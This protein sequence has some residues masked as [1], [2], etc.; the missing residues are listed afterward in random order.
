MGIIQELIGQTIA[1]II[2]AEKGQKEILFT[3]TDG[4]I[5]RMFHSQYC[6]ENV[7]VE[8]VCGDI[9]DLIGCP[10]VRAEAPSTENEPKPSEEYV[11]SWTWTFYILGTQKGTVTF[12]W[13]GESNG[14]YSEDVD[15]EWS[16][17]G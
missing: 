10:I 6:C 1:Q 5:F 15:A 4:R 9:D 14:C 16:S 12:R 11:V 17:T 3:L 7:R 8:D 2:G 13:L